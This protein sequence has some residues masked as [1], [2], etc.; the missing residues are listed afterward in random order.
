MNKTK[1]IAIAILSVFALGC[2]AIAGVLSAQPTRAFA[3]ET[4]KITGANV[5]L[6]ENVV[7]N[8]QAENIT[9]ESAKMSFSFNGKTY[10]QT[11]TVEDGIAKF[12]FDKVT[13]QY[14]CETVSAS[15]TVGD[16]VVDTKDDFT[17][18][19]YLEELLGK[20]AETLGQTEYENQAMQTL[21]VDM[22]HYGAEA[23]KYTNTNESNLATS[24]LTEE[25]K[26]LK[27]EYTSLESSDKIITGDNSDRFT[28]YGAGLRFDYNVSLYFTIATENIEGLSLDVDGT[29]ITEYETNTLDGTNYYIFRYTS[30][31]ATDFDKVYTAKVYDGANQIG[32]TLKYSVK[33]YVYAMQN[34]GEMSDLVKAVYNYGKS[35]EYYAEYF[36]SVVK[37]HKLEAEVAALNYASSNWGINRGYEVS[38]KNSGFSGMGYLGEINY[39]V[40]DGDT[41]TFTV[42]SDRAE[43]A[44]LG[45]CVATSADGRK[46]FGSSASCLKKILL[47]DE[48]LSVSADINV[49]F[50]GWS[51]WTEV[52]L[53]TI[54][55]VKG[56]NTL[57][58]YP[59]DRGFNFDY[60]YLTTSAD[61]AWEKEDVHI[62]SDW[63]VTE[64]PTESTTGRMFRQ[65][66]G[67]ADKEVVVLPVLSDA[68]TSEITRQATE[69]LCELTT[70][71]VGEYSF[72][73]KTKDAT[74]ESKSLKIEAESGTLTGAIVTEQNSDKTF[75]STNKKSGT[76]TY[77]FTAQTS[78]TITLVLNMASNPNVDIY[79][80]NILKLVVNGKSVAID[81]TL[82]AKKNTGGWFG[83]SDYVIA[84]FEVVEG[85]NTIVIESNGYTVK[86]GGYG[87]NIDYLTLNVNGNVFVEE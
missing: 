20:S 76:A 17:V 30:V 53:L 37:T 16:S 79:V 66:N 41:I 63:V 54:N 44:T 49:T 77:T 45:V 72:T 35:A 28:W 15:L 59:C 21:I 22:L 50:G 48:E 78:G 52:E 58:F 83:T 74:G 34:D 64:M 14:F 8:F 62:Y 5:T 65:C 2:G 84:T 18:R 47:N 25:Q 19:G 31:S 3:E 71:T 69:T 42:E 55:L 70:Y 80:D 26:A 10:E 67:C 87:F 60:M 61:V 4:A 32:K 13:P 7:V 68:Y 12:T 82:L 39:N 11:Q 9:E 24:N 75:L 81:E 38:A 40:A 33:S 57:V 86:G 85:E 43:S 36:N 6:N 23:Q 73:I 1:N 56:T 51:S 46:I 27:T 29:K